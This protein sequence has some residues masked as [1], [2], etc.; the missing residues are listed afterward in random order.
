MAENR[1]KQLKGT[2]VS[3]KMEKTVRVRVDTPVRH[4]VYKKIINKKKVFFA[5]TDKK[6]EIGD[7]VVIEESRPY[8]K[9]I[10]W[11]V[12]TQNDTKGN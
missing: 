11:V 9:N 12:K 8:S 5:R 4:P 10:K 1:K 7:E 2:V 3:N 6:L